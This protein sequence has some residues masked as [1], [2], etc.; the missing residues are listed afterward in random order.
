MLAGSEAALELSL[1]VA[2]QEGAPTLFGVSASR[3]RGVW[4]A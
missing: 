3:T 2:E 4:V 1:P